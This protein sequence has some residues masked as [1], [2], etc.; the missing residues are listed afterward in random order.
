MKPVR[1]TRSTR[2][3]RLVEAAYHH[4]AHLESELERRDRMLADWQANERRAR[5]QRLHTIARRVAS[6][7][8]V[9]IAV[10]SAAYIAFN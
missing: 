3:T 7:A 4:S 6:G 2:Y 9:A 8:V 10:A 1:R 5:R